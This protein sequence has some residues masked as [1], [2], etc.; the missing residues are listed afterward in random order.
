MML[1]LQIHLTLPPWIEEVADASRRYL[2]DEERVEL[3]IELSRETF[4]MAVV[5]HSVPPCLTNMAG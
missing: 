3:A 4:N 2:T 5:A 1:P